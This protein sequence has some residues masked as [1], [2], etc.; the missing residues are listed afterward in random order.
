[1]AATILR[2]K[3]EILSDTKV[4]INDSIY[5]PI[6]SFTIILSECGPS[7]LT[8]RTNTQV[9]RQNMSFADNDAR[10]SFC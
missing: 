10:K 7:F 8:S 3:L 6:F 1:M 2:Q 5:R 9:I 4:T